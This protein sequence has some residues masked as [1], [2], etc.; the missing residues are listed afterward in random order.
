MLSGRQQWKN[1]CNEQQHRAW[2]RNRR[3]QKYVISPAYLAYANYI[4][5]VIQSEHRHQ[6]PSGVCAYEV[7]QVHEAAS[8][9]INPGNLI[10]LIGNVRAPGYDASIIDAANVIRFSGE[11]PESGPETVET[12]GISGEH[13][14]RN[15][16][17]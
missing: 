14:S 6:V 9:H 13:A 3:E 10:G 5:G 15:V 1:H 7:V 2:F 8:R 12:I 16:R 4:S 17:S 11:L